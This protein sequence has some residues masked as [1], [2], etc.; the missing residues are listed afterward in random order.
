MRG[1]RIGNRAIMF[2]GTQPRFIKDAYGNIGVGFKNQDNE[3]YASNIYKRIWTFKQLIKWRR[4]IGKNN[5][6][7]LDKK[8]SEWVRSDDI[9]RE[10]NRDE[11]GYYIN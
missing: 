6:A 1:V 3:F 10:A 5:Y 7:I 11:H 2:I 8:G 9:E 4:L